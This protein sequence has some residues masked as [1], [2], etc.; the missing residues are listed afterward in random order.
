MTTPVPP[1]RRR[2]PEVYTRRRE[3]AQA[4]SAARAEWY[5]NRVTFGEPV[6]RP[7]W[8]A[9]AEAIA[10]RAWAEDAAD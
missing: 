6:A 1:T 2:N 10:A 8:L 4:V 3:Q 7:S 9:E 5:R